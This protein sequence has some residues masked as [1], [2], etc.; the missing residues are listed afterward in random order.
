M[1]HLSR[2]R[3]VPPERNMGGPKTRECHGPGLLVVPNMDGCN[4]L[5]QTDRNVCRWLADHRPGDPVRGRVGEG[6][7]VIR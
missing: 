6:E 2:A 5:T 7:E 1:G 4:G 3:Y